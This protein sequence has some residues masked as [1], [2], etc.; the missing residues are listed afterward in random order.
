MALTQYCYENCW[1]TNRE[2][3]YMCMIKFMPIGKECPCIKC[4]LR[5]ICTEM[6]DERQYISNKK[7]DLSIDTLYNHLFKL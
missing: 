7:I 2:K 5:I 3:H 6:C 4:I 1:C